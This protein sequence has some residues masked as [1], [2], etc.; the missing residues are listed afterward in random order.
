MSEQNSIKF[1]FWND[2]ELYEPKARQIVLES[3]TLKVPNCKM[4]LVSMLDNFYKDFTAQRTIDA[5][6]AGKFKT[7]VLVRR[8]EHHRLFG[9]GWVDAGI[10]KQAHE[11]GIK[12]FAFDF[13]YFGHYES[14]MVDTYGPKGESSILVDW[15]NVSDQLDWSTAPDYIQDYRK[16]FLDKVNKYKNEAPVDG[17]VSGQYVV[18][19]PQYSMDLLKPEFKKGSEVRTEVTL[20]LNRCAEA[21]RQAGLTPVIKGGPALADWSRLNVADVKVEHFYLHNEKHLS[22]PR[23]TGGKFIKD[24]NAKLIAHAKYHIVGQSSVTNELVLTESPVVALGQSWFN[25]L[26]IFQEPTSWETVLNDPMRINKEARNKW[27]NWW[28]SKQV[29]KEDAASKFLETYTK[30]PLINVPEKV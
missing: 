27:V 5:L 12:T 22:D 20:W 2:K 9:K 23:V 3:V 24:I 30:Y 15:P 14:Y 28:L 4:Y 29:K 21:V 8:D 6:K 19:W 18:I 17:L 16:N 7:D 1:L 13:G 10:I 11:M 26:D 25:G